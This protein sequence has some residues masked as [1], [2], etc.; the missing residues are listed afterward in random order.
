MIGFK[1]TKKRKQLFPQSRMHRP[2]NGSLT[3]T[4]GCRVVCSFAIELYM[5]VVV[6]HSINALLCCR[7]M[8]MISEFIFQNSSPYVPSPCD[9]S[10]H[11]LIRSG[12]SKKKNH[13]LTNPIRKTS[14][15]DPEEVCFFVDSSPRVGSRI[16]TCV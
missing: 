4:S 14:G 11:P 3:E 6:L 8:M 2:E 7:H 16:Q 13:K 10:F 9:A 5:F 12:G 1:G 15:V